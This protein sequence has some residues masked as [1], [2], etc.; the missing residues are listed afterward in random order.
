MAVQAVHHVRE[1]D[2]L[3]TGGV[4]DGASA[5]QVQ[6]LLDRPLDHRRGERRWQHLRDGPV[7]S[8]HAPLHLVQ[9]VRELGA[10]GV[11]DLF[12]AGESGGVSALDAGSIAEDVVHP[13]AERE[14]DAL[15]AVD[16]HREGRA[17]GLSLRVR[18]QAAHHAVVPRIFERVTAVDE[19]FDDHLVVEQMQGNPVAGVAD[20]PEEELL[21][22][23]RAQPHPEVR[24]HGA[25][26]RE[27][28][29]PDAAERAGGVRSIGT[30]PTHRDVLGR[31][32]LGALTARYECLFEDV[33][34]LVGLEKQ[35][36]EQLPRLVRR[37]PSGPK[38]GL[39]IGRQGLID[40]AQRDG[41]ATGFDLGDQ[42]DEVDALDGLVEGAR[43]VLGHSP[44][45]PGDLLE[46]RRPSGIALARGH[47]LGQVGM[48]MGE[49]DGGAERPDHRVVEEAALAGPLVGVHRIRA[50]GADRR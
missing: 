42:V 49:A 15:R 39:V 44:A 16:L 28:V 47:R 8:A 9:G 27:G 7:E 48:A 21:G 41:I 23:V 32:A 31:L 34:D 30:H 46:L 36:R 50:S 3:D 2:Q 12:E 19:G 38:I 11:P 20:R 22:G 6:P 1:A 14:L 45:D 43:R 24:L 26:V 13:V 25:D 35:E 37:D 18:L 33:P 29:H 4:V 40:A 17:E 10:V 5:G